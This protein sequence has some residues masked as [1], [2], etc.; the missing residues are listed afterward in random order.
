MRGLDNVRMFERSTRPILIRRLS[1]DSH[2]PNPFIDL[3]KLL[4]ST[5]LVMTALIASVGCGPSETTVIQPQD[6][7]MSE[8]EQSNRDR[9]KEALAAQ[10]Q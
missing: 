4:L 2:T 7:Q 8:Q 5:C 3:M 6:Y 9:E 1:F 10:R